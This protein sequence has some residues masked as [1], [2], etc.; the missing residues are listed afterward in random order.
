M[1]AG[2]PLVA[3]GVEDQ[4]VGAQPLLGD[5]VVALVVLVTLPCVFEGAVFAGAIELACNCIL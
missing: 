1:V 2:L 5:A 4:A 3:E